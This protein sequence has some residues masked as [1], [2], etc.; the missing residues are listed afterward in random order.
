LLDVTSNEVSFRDTQ[1]GRQT[2]EQCLAGGES[3]PLDATDGCIGDL[4]KLRQVPLL[5]ASREAEPTQVTGNWAP[6]RCWS[7]GPKLADGG[8]LLKDA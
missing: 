2:L 6:G 3:P 5:Q 7:H 1:R 8:Q 4:C